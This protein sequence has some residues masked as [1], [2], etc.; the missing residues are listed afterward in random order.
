MNPKVAASR[1]DAIRS[2]H[3]KA[4]RIMNAD[5][6]SQD[7]RNESP[8]QTLNRLALEST[9]E[10]TTLIGELSK[11][12]A[13]QL[14]SNADPN[15]VRQAVQQMSMVKNSITQIS[16]TVETTREQLIGINFKAA[17]AA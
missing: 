16:A 4:V 1:K 6:C 5:G 12:T 17:K 3:R 9:Q 2:H 7:R 10:I 15:R 11:L 14:D 8:N 13:M